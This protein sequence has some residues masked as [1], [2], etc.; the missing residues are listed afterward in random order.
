MHIPTGHRC[1]ATVFLFTMVFLCCWLLLT[2]SAVVA[3][4]SRCHGTTA[5]GSLDYGVR[6]PRSGPNFSSYS[7]LAWLAGRTY[8]HSE[9]RAI[10][11]AAYQALRHSQPGKVYVLGETGWKHG[12][13]FRPHKTHQNGLSVDFM[14]PVVD[15][16]GQ[17]VPLPTS[18]FNRFGYAIEFDADSR[19]L[20]LTID[21]AALGAHLV[22]LDRAA[23]ARG[24]GLWRVIF[25]PQLQAGLLQTEYGPY[26]QRHITLSKRRAWVRHDEHYHV[27][28]AIPCPTGA[29]R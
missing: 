17:S 27:D 12:G 18:V 8:V 23:Q 29:G 7:D 25:D 1:F 4:A 26:I 28:F 14:T 9:V 11:L 24:H 2:P 15:A 20:G 10:V 19:A 21:Y 6:L 22:A 5:D 16:N 3:G 13:R